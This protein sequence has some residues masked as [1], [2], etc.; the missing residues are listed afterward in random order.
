MQNIPDV[1]DITASSVD[2]ATKTRVATGAA[3]RPTV[4]E[5]T[6]PPRR[7]SSNGHHRPGGSGSTIDY[8]SPLPPPLPPNSPPA[9]DFNANEF[10][11]PVPIGPLSSIAH[12]VQKM[13]ARN[14]N[15]QNLLLPHLLRPIANND[16]HHPHEVRPVRPTNAGGY[17]PA[18]GTASGSAS[19]PTRPCDTTTKDCYA[20]PLDTA[21]PSPSSGASPMMVAT[22]RSA[23]SA[24]RRHN[25][26]YSQKISGHDIGNVVQ[27]LH[28]MSEPTAGSAS[29]STSVSNCS[30][31]SSGFGGIG[32]GGSSMSS[33]SS[34]SASPT[35]ETS[36]NDPDVATS[37]YLTDEHDE[38]GDPET[39]SSNGML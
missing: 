8:M 12:N 26:R 18:T 34:V 14:N 7:P 28:G 21:P 2:A 4:L 27:Q 24:M 25:R 30:T 29:S 20:S 19:E 13:R 16:G 35:A 1:A 36:R 5:F 10:A 6:T 17:A 38:C 33:G 32:G 37:D 3:H 31:T 11:I 9:L 23:A 22:P 15:H 39:Q